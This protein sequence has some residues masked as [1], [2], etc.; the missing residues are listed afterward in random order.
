MPNIETI[1][2]TA[3]KRAAVDR[4]EKTRNALWPEAAGLVWDRKKEKGFCTIP[5]TL[6]LI[7]TLI[8]E[9]AKGK[10]AA[11]VYCELWTR[12]FDEGLVEV[13]D[14]EAMAFGAGYVTPGRGVRTWRERIDILEDYGFIEVKP[15]GSRKYGF[16]L[17]RHPHQVIRELRDTKLL[18]NE[19]WWGAFIKRAAEIGAELPES[20]AKEET[21]V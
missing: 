13:L 8:D 1:V 20:S 17:L 11:Q 14:E 16:V 10:S 21:T 15:N 7:M 4:R 2:K 3:R 6:P 5:R 19:N 12:A 18:P 9:L